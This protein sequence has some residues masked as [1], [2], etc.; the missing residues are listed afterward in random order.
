MHSFD[1]DQY[2]TAAMKFR[3]NFGWEIGIALTKYSAVPNANNIDQAV[4]NLE[5][6]TRAHLDERTPPKTVS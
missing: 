4:S 1:L 6:V 3:Q 2:L 5:T